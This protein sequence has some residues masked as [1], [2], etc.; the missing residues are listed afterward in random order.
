VR[1]LPAVGVVTGALRL[2]LLGLLHRVS[3][4]DIR[5]RSAYVVQLDNIKAEPG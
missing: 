1:L 4:I 2:L 3:I 5:Y